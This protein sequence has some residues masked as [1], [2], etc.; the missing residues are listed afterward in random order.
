MKNTRLVTLIGYSISG[1]YAALHTLVLLIFFLTY[2]PNPVVDY[3]SGHNESGETILSILLFISAVPIL[4]L[5]LHYLH[6]P[7]SKKYGVTLLLIS[8]A[9]YWGIFMFPGLVG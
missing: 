6:K 2:D 8:A 3:S 7:A 1:F 9:T 4:V 5:G